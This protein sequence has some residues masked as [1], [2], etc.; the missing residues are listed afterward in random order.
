MKIVSIE[1]KNHKVLGDFIFDFRIDDSVRDF[2]LLVGENGCGKTILLEEIFKIISGGI[3]PWDDG[4]DRKIV[5]T[6]AETE[7]QALGITTD[8]ITFSYI[9][10]SKMGWQRI[11]AFDKEG[12]DITSQMM[13]KIQGD[14]FKKILKEAYSTVE[15]N[16]TAKEIDAVRATDIDVDKLPKSRSNTDLASEIAQLLVDI[17]AQDDAEWGTWG[18]ANMGKN[19]PIPIFNGKLSRFKKAYAKMFVGKELCDVRPEDNRHK[20]FFKDTIKN[21]EFDISKLSSGEKQV[22]YRAGY[23]LKNLKNLNGGIVLIDEPELSLHPQWQIKYLDF[24]RDLFQDESGQIDIQFIIATHSPFILKG[25]LRNDVSVFLFVKDNSGKITAQNAHG[26]G[27][28]LFKWS[29]SWGEINYFAYNLP[30]IEFHDELFGTL[31]E[32][33]ID[34]ATDE[35]MA[36]KRSFMDNFDL[37]VLAKNIT[38]N[39]NENWS[40]LK[41]GVQQPPQKVTLSAFVR[42]SVHHPE[43]QQTRKYN[44][45]DLENSIKYMLSIL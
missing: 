39:Q 7:K 15:I 33:F 9:E 24:L 41:N 1:F 8:L 17:K 35:E 4:I 2:S 20:I 22:V 32:R 34:A 45:Q 13:P 28:G 43:S 27:F 30:T 21:I 29:P 3:V 16:F 37:E 12:L 11:Q 6:L 42:N 18:R 40:K 25:V 44:T 10:K 38:T 14:D 36:R 23:L 19:T 5:V 26:K 31:H